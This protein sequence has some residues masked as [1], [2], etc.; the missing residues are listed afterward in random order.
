MNTKPYELQDGDVIL[1]PS[2]TYPK[3]VSV[4]FDIFESCM[5]KHYDIIG[6]MVRK[7]EPVYDQ[8]A[9]MYAQDSESD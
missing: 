1:P 4:A 6:L 9:A 8:L 2:D 7:K 3:A 5:G